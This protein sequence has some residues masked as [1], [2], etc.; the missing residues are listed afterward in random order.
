MSR[1]PLPPRTRDVLPTRRN[2]GDEERRLREAINR[3][4]RQLIDT[5]DC[6][7]R[8]RTLPQE[9]SRMRSVAMAHLKDFAQAAMFAHAYADPPPHDD[10]TDCDTDQAKIRG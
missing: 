1:E 3:I 10:A 7:I 2:E 8:P 4:S 6:A 9:G 5:M